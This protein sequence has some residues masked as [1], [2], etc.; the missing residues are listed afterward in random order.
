MRF[1][2][3]RWAHEQ[4]AF[5][6]G[7]GIFA[8]ESLRVH[9]RAL[10]RLRVLRGPD[11][12]VGEISDVAFEVAMLVAFGDASAVHHEGSAFAGAAIAGDGKFSGSVGAGD[13]L[14]AGSL[15]ELAILE[16]H[17]R[18]EHT[19]ARGGQ[20]ELRGVER[21][22]RKKSYTEHTERRGTESHRDRKNKER[23]LSREGPEKTRE[24]NRDRKRC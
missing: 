17:R 6:A 18:N 16:R 7:A 3:A 15:A 2:H 14:P 13:Q 23:D 4:Q 22:G 10:E 20:Q 9:V 12:A 11:F 8:D 1:S 19:G 5:F 24:R 21:C